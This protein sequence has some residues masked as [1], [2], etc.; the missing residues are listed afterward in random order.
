MS[1][2]DFPPEEFEDRL[3]R[4]R[5]AITVAGLDWMLLFHPVSIHWL[6]GSDAKSYQTFQC[7][8]ISAER[9]PLVMFTRESERNEYMDDTL[10]DEIRSWGGP[11]PE[12]PITALARVLDDLGVRR[13]RV[14]IEVP[15]YYMHPH[16]YLRIKSY[17]GDA[18]TSEPTNLI[19]DLKAVKSTLEIAAVREAAR[20]AD[21][22]MT[23][24]AQALAEGRTE[25]ELAGTVYYALLRAGS[26]LPA[27]T[28]NLVSGPRACFSHGGPT[29]RVLRSGD[30][31]NVEFGATARRY[32][33]TIG[34]H[35]SIGP[36]SSRARELD[37]IVREACDAMIAAIRHGVP[38]V[39]PHEAAKRV[40]AQAGLDRYRIHT[41]GYGLAPGFPPSWGEPLVMYGD[42]TGYLAAGMVVSI[43]PPIFIHQ[44][45]MGARLIDNVLVTATG[46]ELLAC[47]PREIIV[48]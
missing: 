36:P 22:A 34:R 48:G 12:D 31:G 6:I 2:H 8:P 23:A 1:K 41:S 4:T 16:N 9:R 43:E 17:L 29:A 42:A 39:V 5:R 11:E 44:E 24:F 38:A 40:I 21:H 20:Y 26:G 35:F 15:A 14:G 33:A 18:L 32:T 13:G 30:F 37:A 19:H 46:A 45:K 28:I 10:A 7:L 47:F 27:S 25:L 3:A